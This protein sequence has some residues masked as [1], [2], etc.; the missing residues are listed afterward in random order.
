MVSSGGPGLLAGSHAVGIASR[1]LRGRAGSVA[2]VFGSLSP[3]WRF[4]CRSSGTPISL[5]VATEILVFALF[6][7]SLQLLIGVGGLVSFGH[8]AYF[9]LGAYGA[10]LA[11]KW[12]GAPMEVALPLALVLAALGAAIF[13][14]FIVRL[15][16]IYLAMLTLAAAQIL[17]AVAFQWVDVTGG[18]NG[19]VG[20]W[21]SPW[22]AGRN[23]Y[24]LFSLALV[25]VA[26]MLIGASSTRPSATRC[27]Q[28]ATPNSGR[29]PSALPCACSAGSPSRLPGPPRGLPAGS[30]YSRAARSIRP[31]SASR[32]PWTHSPCCSSAA[33]RR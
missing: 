6:A 33:S 7:F 4:C 26:V 3:S 28:R 27:A 11:V 1:A 5:K 31:S 20:I 32:P 30:T 17:F 13:G 21:P 8:A 12:L 14:A 18:D 2:A 24:Y 25:A 29:T 10:A 9:G 22:A 23:A 19:I 16:G 15:S